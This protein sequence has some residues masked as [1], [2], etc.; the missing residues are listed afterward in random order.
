MNGW[1]LLWRNMLYRKSLSLLTIFAVAVTVSLFVLLLLCKDGFERGAA[2]G[3]GPFELVIGAEGSESQLVLNTFYRAGAPTGNIPLEVL[4]AVSEENQVDAAFGMTAG[5]HYNGFPIV[6]M[7][8]A[9]FPVR[10]GDRH[11]KEGRLYGQLGE[12][13][14]GYAAAQSLG[15]RVGDQ[16]SGAH[17]LIGHHELEEEHGDHEEDAHESFKYTVVGVL[18]KL[19]TADDRAIFTTMD[20]AWAV[21]DHQQGAREVTAILVKPKSLL[22]A[23]SVKQK[24]DQWD[25]VQAVYTSKAVADLLNMVDT[26]SQ[27]LTLVMTI[28]VLLAASSLLL[29]LT[30]AFHER[31]K[32]IGLL[33][34]I[35]KSKSYILLTLLGEGM[36]LTAAGLAAGLLVGHAAGWLISEPLFTATGIQLEGFRLSANEVYI[37]ASALALGAIA[38]IIP[39]VR[40]YRVDAQSLFRS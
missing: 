37:T 15:V 40:L 14:L 33:R 10:Y 18:P 29:S 31:K 12:V 25:R 34:L 38:S 20:Y 3:Y 24:Y 22:G 16:F 30:A 39:A 13:T 1:K 21:H 32:D 28:C 9:Y 19:N 6:G 36:V 11:L 35:G 26:G 23:Q 4:Q 17:G 7:D 2:N 5:D 8:P 27:I